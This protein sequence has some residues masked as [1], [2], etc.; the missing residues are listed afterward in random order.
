MNGH[1]LYHCYENS[2]YELGVFLLTSVY[3]VGSPQYLLNDMVHL[4]TQNICF[5]QID[6]KIITILRI[7]VHVWL[8][9]PL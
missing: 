4:I 7:H 8:F 1:I 6:K 5:K 9:A 3:V 2:N